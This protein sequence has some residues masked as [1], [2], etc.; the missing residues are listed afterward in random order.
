M[1]LGERAPAWT[2]NT[3]A[4]PAVQDF[5]R[6]GYHLF[7]RPVDPEAAGKLLAE[8]RADRR[9]DQSLFQGEV[10]FDADPQYRGVNPRPGR[11]LLERF[12]DDLGFV[13]QA[14]HIVSALTA[15]LG[16]GYRIMDRKV[17]CGVPDSAI[18]AWLKTRIAGNPVNNLGPYVKPRYRDVTYFNGID[19]HQDLIDYKD[20]EADFITLYVYL[21]PVTRADAPLFVLENSHSLGASVFPHDLSPPDKIGDGEAWTYRNGPQGEA[22]CRQ[23]VLT[24]GAGHVACWH[25]LT[26]HGTQPDEADDERI[27]LRYLFAPADGVKAGLHAVNEG[28]GVPLSLTATRLD[29]DAAGA[30]QIKANTVNG[31]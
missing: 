14:P 10:E 4:E 18:P 27:S 2:S 29:L 6:L 19:F 12:A 23:V 15:L 22:R 5:A 17:V 1:D 16:P 9:Y 25:A 11:N 28:L 31:A 8:L 24:G 13:E 30:A 20:R 7:D 3:H 26:L 21:H